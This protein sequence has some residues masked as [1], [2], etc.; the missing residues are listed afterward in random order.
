M[1][2]LIDQS[3]DVRLSMAKQR[4]GVLVSM[5]LCSVPALA[6]EEGER[7]ASTQEAST[8]TGEQFGQE[9]RQEWEP[10]RRSMAQTRVPHPGCFHASYPS[11]QWQEVECVPAPARLYSPASGLRPQ[12]AGNGTDFTVQA[13]GLI[14]SAEGSFPRVIGV[15]SETDEGYADTYSLQLNSQFFQSTVCSKAQHPSQCY[16]WEQ[17]AYTSSASALFIEDWLFNYGPTCP[18]TSWSSDNKG[19]CVNGS[20]AVSPPAQAITNLA[21]L[22]LTGQVYGGVSTAILSTGNGQ[23]YA[24][25]EI[26][27]VNLGPAWNS[28]EFNVFGDG[29]LTQAVFNS[30]ST[31][32]VK[33]SI[34]NGATS[35]PSCKQEGFTGETNN[36]TL[37]ATCCPLSDAP[38]IVF[39]ESNAV[40][41]KLNCVVYEVIPALVP[42]VTVLLL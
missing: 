11:V 40:G 6:Q 7:P 12:T 23:L 16:G 19:N 37:V 30:G 15:T 33:T 32:V 42:I 28:A 13:S 4:A 1:K 9:N 21:N 2:V 31:I 39:M 10:W 20:K 22:T 36:L 29:G 27:L 24:S 26:S 35:A 18:T 34:V 25:S 3:I 5:L 17:F 38:G 14:S 8:P 41:A